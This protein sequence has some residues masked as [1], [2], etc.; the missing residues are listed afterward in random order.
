M[1]VA[2]TQVPHVPDVLETI[3]QLPNDDV[4]TR[5]AV[6][7]AMLDILPE[8]VWSEPAYKWLD[9]ATKSG[10]YL[11]E[12]FNR[13]MRGL[14][15]WEPDGMKRREHILRQMI[16]GAATT[17]INGEIARR[18]LY[19]TKNATGTEVKDASLQG[20]VVSFEL[21]DG[22]V[23]FVETEHSFRGE[24][25]NRRCIW[26][27]APEALVRDSREHYAYSFVHH[28]YPTAEL[29]TMQFDVIV[30][31]PPYQIG[32]EGNTRTRPLYQL[33]VE[34]AIALDPRYIVMITPSRWFTGGLGLDEYR[35]KMINDRRLAKLVDNPKL[36]DVFPGVEIKGGVSYFLWDREHNGDCEFSTRIDGAVVS[37]ATRDLREGHGVVIRDNLASA[38]VHKVM[39]ESEGS[40]EEW[41]YPRL[42]FSQYW[43]TNYRG[44]SDSPFEGSIPLIHNS[45]A[46]YVSPAG[47]ERNLDLVGKWK[48]LLPMAGDGHG[49]EVSYVTGEPIAIAP[50]SVCTESYFVAG[51][52]DSR[53]ECEHYA[54]FLSTKFARFLVLQ[55][56]STQH[57]TSDRY[58]FVPALPMDT[59][60]TD[61]RLYEHFGLTNEEVA[62]IEASIHPRE[63][64]FS[65]DS[66]IPASHLPGGSKYRAGGPVIEPDD[67]DDGDEA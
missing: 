29:E 1:T 54:R 12:I 37:T 41:F 4:Y 6:V 25:T 21:P 42:A 19:Q 15:E 26:C 62:Y 34:R 32:V 58:R 33:F 65:L 43:R 40:V 64:V 31:N 2:G 22:N 63:P 57:I 51:A 49:R 66:A 47:F 48:V 55:R 35:D 9:P 7:N 8:H 17:Q 53:E 61:E 27:G 60:W 52:F 11:R 13:L 10:V 59:V 46:G 50:G 24:G 45:G 44:E 20:L 39:A 56:K 67:D 30:G 16:Y 23:P 3:A 38:L 28:T 14:A 5:P 18:T 36:F